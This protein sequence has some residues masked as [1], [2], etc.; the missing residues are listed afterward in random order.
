MPVVSHLDT[1]DFRVYDV[2]YT[3]L[4]MMVFRSWEY[5]FHGSN[6]GKLLLVSFQFWMNG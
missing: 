5:G 1:G 6:F 3:R 2:M 4:E